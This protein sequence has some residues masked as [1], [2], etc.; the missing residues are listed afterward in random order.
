MN[1]KD[2]VN[3]YNQ[4]K[5]PDG[6]IYNYTFSLTKYK[7]L[8]VAVGKGTTGHYHYAFVL[9][10]DIKLPMCFEGYQK[11]FFLTPHEAINDAIDA[12][13]RRIKDLK[14]DIEKLQKELKDNY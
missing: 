6:I 2:I 7:I 5:I 4:G 10:M 3:L 9:Q 1:I 14:K 12:K 11:G 13:Q 8:S